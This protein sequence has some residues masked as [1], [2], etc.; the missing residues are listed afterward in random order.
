MKR[1]QQIVV[2]RAYRAME[3]DLFNQRDSSY[4][5]KV[6]IDLL[7]VIGALDRELA[8]QRSHYEGSPE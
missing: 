8:Q 4:A 5:D 3:R 6:V 1:G 7:R 2:D